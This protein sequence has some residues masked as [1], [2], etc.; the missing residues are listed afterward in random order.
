MSLY[1]MTT[2]RPSRLLCVFAHP[3]DEVFCVG[4]TV[5]RWVASG[6]EAMVLSA[7]RGEAGQIQDASAATRR[8]LG[9]VREHELHLACDEL[10]VQWVECLDY[11]DGTLRDV[12][13]MALAHDVA[14]RID[15][16][17]PDVVVTFG[18]DGGYEH[19][20]HI[21]ISAATTLA[22]QLIARRDGRA[23]HLYYSAFPRQHQLI[24]RSLAD[25]L[26]EREAS[27]HG[28]SSFIRGFTLLAEEAT[29]MRYA[30]DAVETQWFPEGFAIV[31]QGEQASSLY[32]I[33]TGN[34]EAVRED[35]DGTRHVLR[36]L[37]PGEFFGERALA[38]HT[39]HEAS[40][41]ATDTVTCLVLSLQEPSSFAGRGEEARLGGAAV[42]ASEGDE[43]EFERLIGVDISAQID[44]KIAALAAH[45]TQFSIDLATFPLALVRDLLGSEY[46]ERVTVA[47]PISSRAAEVA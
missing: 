26:T 46:F 41:I 3:D 20:D 14:A 22:C 10:G 35:D 32:L 27:F 45:R 9:A 39:P 8:T 5:A 23:P 16:F 19:P 24:C 21:A 34:V 11:L 44:R 13:V 6:G 15:N 28:S 30:D 7:T 36:R 29:L 37:G 38:R 4:G 12:G 47:T 31:E 17:R 40:M 1:P 42:G 43:Q 33:V 2:D 18:L 25:W